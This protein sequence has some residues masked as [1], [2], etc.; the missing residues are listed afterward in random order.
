MYYYS[1]GDHQIAFT[2]NEEGVKL[3]EDVTAANIGKTLAIFLDDELLIAPIVETAI[4]DGSGVIN[5][6]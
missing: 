5:A 6:H 4:T 3:F 1:E 2:L